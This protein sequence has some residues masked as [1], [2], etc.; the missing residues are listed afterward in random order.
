MQA[1]LAQLPS[2]ADWERLAAAR[3]L[4]AFLEEARGGVLGPWIKGFSAHSQVPDLERGLRGLAGERI[5]QVADWVPEPWR[6]AVL[7]LAWLPW[8]P[9]I[10]HLARGEPRPDWL[11]DYAAGAFPGGDVAGPDGR[12]GERRGDR[13]RKASQP[14]DVLDRFLASIGGEVAQDGEGI[15]GRWLAGWIARWP[16]TGQESRDHL[17]ALIALVGQHLAAFRAASPETAWDR[18]RAL[19]ERLRLGFRRQPL[20][21]VAVFAY[22]GLVF[23]DLERLRGELIRRA[24]FGQEP[25]G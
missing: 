7:W 12:F 13:D 6:A 10:E 1:R 8:L 11:G 16:S 15:G 25:T 23:L 5:E 3:T 18:R 17:D 4:S 19:R 9:L 24:L 20:T 2:E 22:L 21:A 14:M